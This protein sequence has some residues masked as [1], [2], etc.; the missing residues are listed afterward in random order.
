MFSLLFAT[1]AGAVEWSS[2]NTQIWLDTSLTVAALFGVQAVDPSIVGVANGG[3][4]PTLNVDDGNLNYRRRGLIAAPLSG[5][6]EL[7]VS[8]GNAGVFF[9]GA[10]W[11]DPR[12]ASRNDTDRT[13]LSDGARDQIAR[14]FRLLNAYAYGRAQ[15]GGVPIDVKLGAVALNWG[16]SALTPNGISIVSPFDLTRLRTP[17]ALIRDALLPVPMLDVTA[18]LAPGV[19]L[20]GFVQAGQP[21]TLF[22]PVGTFFSTSDLVGVGARSLILGAAPPVTD[23]PPY[24][25][26][27]AIPRG[28]DRDPDRAFQY[29]LALRW[30]PEQ[31]DGTELGLY[32]IQYNSRLP[33]FSLRTGSVPPAL[34]A[35]PALAGIA[36][37]GSSSYASDYPGDIRLA[38]ASIS[39]RLPGELTFR[40]EASWRFGQP[41]QVDFSELGFAGLSPFNPVF[42]LSQVGGFGFNQAIQGWRRHDVGT[43]IASLS[44]TVANVLGSD[45]LS[46]L[47]EGGLTA[48]PTLPGQDRLR[49]AGAGSY[50]SGNPLFTAIGA[51]SY[52]TTKGFASR[53]SGGYRLVAQ[54]DYYN[55]IGSVT[56]SPRLAFSHDVAG[57]TPL[58]LGTYVRGRKAVSVGVT[59][60]W[61]SRWSAGL[62]YVSFFGAGSANLLR[63]RDY[64]ASYLRATF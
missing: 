7:E 55:L 38:G 54:L 35:S 41:L 18:R 11:F 33:T 39:T 23:T 56:V 17:G 57:I 14:G 64:V 21:R 12:N 47:G 30:S 32:W 13:P 62:E 61:L 5:F 2:G 60:N 10:Y 1:R 9:A 52:T 24:L 22:D 48:I 29:G 27:T 3:R 63:D 40:A 42:A 15:P 4:L 34:L 16:K 20:E 51:Q 59:A 6:S 53:T 58:P 28:R 49:F 25:P 50:T 43:L 46:L 26:G 36:F 44:R 8:R 37:A 45:Q 19:S 31:A